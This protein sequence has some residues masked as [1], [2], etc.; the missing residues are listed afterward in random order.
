[1]AV[2]V[3]THTAVVVVAVLVALELAQ[4]HQQLA[5]QHLELLP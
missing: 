3:I 1:V 5:P 4:L 2:A